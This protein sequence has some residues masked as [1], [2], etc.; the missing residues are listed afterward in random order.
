MLLGSVL[1]DG[2]ADGDAL[3]LLLGNSVGVVDA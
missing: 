3:G 1:V 2:D